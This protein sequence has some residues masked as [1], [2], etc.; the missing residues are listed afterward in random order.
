MQ[1]ASEKM[2]DRIITDHNAAAPNPAAEAVGQW[3]VM[4][5]V[6]GYVVT[7]GAESYGMNTNRGSPYKLAERL[8]ALPASPA[9]ETHILCG[10]K[11]CVFCGAPPIT[12]PHDHT[13]VYSH[14]THCEVCTTC[15]LAFFATEPATR[16]TLDEAV[17]ALENARDRLRR[18]RDQ[19][20]DY[21]PNVVTQIEAVLPALRP[22][23]ATKGETPAAP[24]PADE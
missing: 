20:T 19:S 15:G 4:F 21:A 6:D 17:V 23:L 10:G 16:E 7:N 12:T 22:L 1:V 9:P 11:G 13:I 3:D 2:A 24:A 18:L 5:D 8:N 14:L